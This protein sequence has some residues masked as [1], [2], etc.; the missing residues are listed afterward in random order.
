LVVY[1]TTV[2]IAERH[3]SGATTYPRLQP[4]IE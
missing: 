2:R 4:V 3:R 1:R